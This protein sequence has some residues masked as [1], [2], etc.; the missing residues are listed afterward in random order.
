M[1]QIRASQTRANHIRATEISS[2]HRE[3]HGTIFL[4]GEGGGVSLLSIEY[5][6][7]FARK[8]FVVGL[9]IICFVAEEF[10]GDLRRHC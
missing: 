9:K 1:T 3:L 2:N 8:D 10:L 7:S 6:N 5:L 4:L